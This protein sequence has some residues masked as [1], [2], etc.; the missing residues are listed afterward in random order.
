VLWSVYFNVD[1]TSQQDL[2]SAVDNILVVGGPDQLIDYDHT[3]AQVAG[4]LFSLV[5]SF[6]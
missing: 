2:T 1:N 4:A 6:L 3:I 5:S